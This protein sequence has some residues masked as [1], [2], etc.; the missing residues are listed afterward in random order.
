[1]TTSS[2]ASLIER[3]GNSRLLAADQYRQACHLLGKESD[4]E[5]GALRLVAADLVTRWQAKQLLTSEKPKFFIGQYKL[6]K[7]LGRGSMG[8]V[9]RA[10]HSTMARIV[11][12][13]V[14][15]KEFVQ[16]PRAVARFEREIRTA[17]ALDHP[18]IVHALDAGRDKNLYYLVMEHVDGKDLRQW[19]KAAG[20]L[21]IPWSC[22]CIRQAAL[23]LQHALERGVTHR[24]IKPSN[25][26]V[27]G[28]VMTHEPEVK[29]VDFGLARVSEALAGD[30]KLTRVG[31]TVGTWEYMAPEQTQNS[32]LA[33]IR[34]DLFGLGCTFFQMVTGELPYQGK[35]DVESLMLRVTSDAPRLRQWNPQIDDRLDDIIAKMLAR[36]PADRFQTPAEVVA[37]LDSLPLLKG[38]VS[39]EPRSCP[40][41]AGETETNSSLESTD[42]EFNQF[43][44]TTPSTSAIR[45]AP[46]PV[47]QSLALA[48]GAIRRSASLLLIGAL[49]IGMWLLWKLLL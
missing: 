1:M 41:P 10:F 32:S 45:L 4:A 42:P 47:E 23:G 22:Q 49:L 29:I 28:R 3:L 40:H 21:P 27:R 17:A 8:I 18:H 9:Y 15:P 37:A 16:D 30:M 11:A 39:S 2:L 48:T 34:S 24:D 44:Q 20:T 36:K 31:R 35:S 43:L 13:K 46:Q 33:D 12:V 6:L 5:Q 19:I 26:L 7:E 14:L 25:I 38:Q